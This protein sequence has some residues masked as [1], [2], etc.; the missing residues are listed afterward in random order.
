LLLQAWRS[1][2]IF[3]PHWQSITEMSRPAKG[4]PVSQNI[5]VGLQ[6]ICLNKNANK[7]YLGSDVPKK[8]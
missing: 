7:T 1:D 4:L 2:V 5:E 3:Y 8:E 6:Q